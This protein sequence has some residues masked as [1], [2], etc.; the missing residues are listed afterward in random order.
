V[1]KVLFSNGFGREQTAVGPCSVRARYGLGSL[2]LAVQARYGDVTVRCSDRRSA[3]PT[4][5]VVRSQNPLSLGSS[6]S[7]H[8]EWLG[9]WVDSF[10]IGA[11]HRAVLRLRH[12]RR[13]GRLIGVWVNDI[14][15]TVLPLDA[16]I[17]QRWHDDVHC[18]LRRSAI[19]LLRGSVGRGDVDMPE[20]PR[21][22]R[23][24]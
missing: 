9:R 24:R 17:G 22:G 11:V 8:G 12:R 6:S 20:R 3:S 15:W 21:R 16:E 13:G 2:A 14:D 4:T 19:R 18:R 1:S 7:G 23:L 5:P 10:P